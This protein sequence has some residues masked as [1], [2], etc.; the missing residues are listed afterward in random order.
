[1]A[2]DVPQLKEY[3][4]MKRILLILT[5]TLISMSLPMVVNAEEAAKKE[6][7][8]KKN[9]FE[10]FHKKIEKMEKDK[11]KE[12]DEKKKEKIDEK[13]AK[14][15]EKLEKTVKKMTDPLEK[16]IEKIDDAMDKLDAEKHAKKIEKMQKDRDELAAKVAEIEAFANPEGAEEPAEDAKEDDVKKAGK[17]GKDALKKVL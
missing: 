10:K 5:V 16:K 15:Q 17:K 13:I 4:I 12:K 9:P 2:S 6:D 7:P 8:K 3:L 1:M 11:E 14:E